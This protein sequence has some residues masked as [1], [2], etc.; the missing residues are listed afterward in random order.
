MERDIRVSKVIGHP[1]P[2]FRTPGTLSGPLAKT[3]GAL[4]CQEV[5]KVTKSNSG[6][7]LLFGPYIG[8]SKAF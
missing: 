4:F 3:S 1:E 6:T 2:I 8:N 7:K 5:M